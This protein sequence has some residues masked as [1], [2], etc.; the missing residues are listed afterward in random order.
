MGRW[1]DM[2]TASIA[3]AVLALDLASP[4]DSTSAPLP[5]KMLVT[6]ALDNIHNLKRPGQEGYATVWDGDKYVQCHFLSDQSLACEAA[7]VMMQSSMRRVLTAEKRLRLTLMGWWLDPSFGNY[8]Q[9]FPPSLS[10]AQVSDLVL[11]ALSQAY[12]ADLTQ[13]EV[14]TRWVAHEACPPRHG[15]SQN[16]AGMIDDDSSMA[17]TAV[18]AC[19][20]TPNPNTISPS[21]KKTESEIIAIYSSRITQEIQRLRINSVQRVFLIIQTDGGYIQC[22]PQRDSKAIYCEAESAESWPLLARLLTPDRIEHLHAA[23]FTDPGRAPNYWKVYPFD[24]YTD[25]AIAREAL[26]VLNEVY[27]Y[28]GTGPIQIKTEQGG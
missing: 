9:I 22:E 8:T 20:Y 27:D 26:S 13:L 18:H 5:A 6:E 16:L 25:E 10:A 24:H 15:P 1:I 19:A 7:G 2:K 12:D 17:S 3:L 28:D 23:G 11:S 4:R 21:S 14:Q